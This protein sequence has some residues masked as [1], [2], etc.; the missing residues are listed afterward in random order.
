MLILNDRCIHYI[1]VSSVSEV[2]VTCIFSCF[3]TD[4]FCCVLQC[5]IMSEG[6]S[7]VRT[8]LRYQTGLTVMTD[9]PT[10]A[11]HLLLFFLFI[12]IFFS[13]H[14]PS[15]LI[16]QL[17]INLLY[18]CCNVLVS[19]YCESLFCLPLGQLDTSGQGSCNLAFPPIGTI[20]KSIWC[21]RDFF[22]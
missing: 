22:F 9:W 16:V 8:N 7:G 2:S 21:N 20:W 18:L 14:T 19:F 13:K 6:Y 15:L 17:S 10:L 11:H 12:I 4:C 5:G 3:V 1:I